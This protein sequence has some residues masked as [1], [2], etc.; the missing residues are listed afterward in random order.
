MQSGDESGEFSLCYLSSSPMLTL[1]FTLLA[2]TWEAFV[3]T[4]AFEKECLETANRISS[5]SKSS[6]NSAERISP[7]EFDD[8]TSSINSTQSRHEVSNIEKHLY[9]VGINGSDRLGPK[10]VF[11]TSTD[12][13][14]PPLGPEHTTRN[15]QILGVYS[16]PR[17]SQNTWAVV[18]VEIVKILDELDVQ[19]TS[20][21]LVRFRWEETTDT[22]ILPYT[23]PITVWIGVLPD[24]T[25]G[26]AAF[27]SSQ[28]ILQC[29]KTYHIEDIDIA[30]RESVGHFLTAND[31]LVLSAPVDRYD[32]LTGFIHWIT[33]ALSLPISSLRHSDIGGSMG[34]YF[35]A[36]QQ[37]YGVT[38]R[39][40]LFPLN[41]GNKLYPSPDTTPTSSVKVI[42]MSQ[43]VFDD[44]LLSI[45][46]AIGELTNDINTEASRL[47]DVLRKK[48]DAGDSRAKERLYYAESDLSQKSGKIDALKSYYAKMRSWKNP[49]SRVIGH[50]VHAFPISGLNPPHGYTIDA[51]VIHLD[52]KKFTN[53]LGNVVD[54]GTKF[55]PG[56]FISLMNPRE[57]PNSDFV[58]PDDGHLRLGG[59][60]TAAQMNTSNTLDAN[61]EPVRY[62]IKHGCNTQTT[63]G[64][65]NGF[66]SYRRLYGLTGQ[67]NSEEAAIVPYNSYLSP[68]SKGGD[69]GSLIVGSGGQFIAL[70]TA[71]TG[72]TGS[73]DVTYATPMHWLWNDVIKLR[74]PD[75]TLDVGPLQA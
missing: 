5:G 7:W 41:E 1:S 60:L 28:A 17:L 22:A 20:I 24:S 18:L 65:L 54:L 13:F 75:A 48:A 16:H 4:P 19:F 62:V 42:L 71:G 61:G 64:K 35:R 33:T 23:T 73:T 47:V 56:K 69:S 44:L 63:I 31:P 2:A 3:K 70:L 21:D 68:F 74:F 9:Y 8:D 26:Q 36:E 58:W 10:L 14:T 49:K 32:F 39:H 43:P 6:S 67:F 27:V 15:M 59:V 37:L 66:K 52:E 53:F 57:D 11:R 30:Y 50:V 40:V 12:V 46:A 34:F 45:Q 29:L 72:P 38:A 25:T 51:S 55:G